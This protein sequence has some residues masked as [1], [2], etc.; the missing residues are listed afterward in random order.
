[1]AKKGLKNYLPVLLPLIAAIVVV[2]VLAVSGRVANKTA[3]PTQQVVTQQAASPKE[4]KVADDAEVTI[5]A[6]GDNL[7]HNTLIDAGRQDDGSYDFTSFYENMKPY[8]ESADIAIINQ[9]TM[10]GGSSFKYAGYP[11]FNS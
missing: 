8:I 7:I 3:S 4:T 6:V 2:S 9:E 1:M 11:N 5:V 10:L